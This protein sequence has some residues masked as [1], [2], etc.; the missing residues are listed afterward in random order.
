MT[1][2]NQQTT[3]NDQ[4]SG[5]AKPPAYVAFSV[6]DRGEKSFWTRIGAAWHHGDEQGL[7]IQLDLV[8]VSGSRIVL[9]TP[10]ADPAQ[11]GQQQGA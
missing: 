5:S 6:L 2:R 1:K 9:R 10:P 8:P 3:P 7:T 4:P 11:N